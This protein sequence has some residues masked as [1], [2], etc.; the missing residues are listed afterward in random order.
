MPEARTANW[1]VSQ[2]AEVLG[3]RTGGA[4]TEADIRQ[5]IRE[6]MPVNADGTVNIILAATWAL[7]QRTQR[8]RPRAHEQGQ[9]Y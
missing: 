2:L 9:D 5:A 4:I 6:G 8:R 7:W 1:P 3:A